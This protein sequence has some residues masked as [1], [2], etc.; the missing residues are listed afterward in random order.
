MGI[1]RWI[2]SVGFPHRI[3]TPLERKLLDELQALL[4]G[5]GGA[6]FAKQLDA[7]NLVQRHAHGQEVC[8]YVMRQGK[9]FEDPALQFPCRDSEAV[10]AVIDFS[11]A[12][13][14]RSWVA[15]FYLVNG[16]FVSIYFDP[17]PSAIRRAE[18]VHIENAR[19]VQDPMTA[20]VPPVLSSARPE[21]VQFPEWL[22]EVGSRTAIQG[23]SRP[24][25]SQER[26]LLRSRINA[27]LPLDYLELMELC[28]GFVIGDWSV[29]GLSETWEIR[30]PSGRYIALAERHGLGLLAVRARS[31][32]RMIYYL[33]YDGADPTAV[34]D[35]LRAALVRE[36]QER[37]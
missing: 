22:D 6:R 20:R 31:S 28:E 11:N 7:I 10:F 12:D 8:C 35:S 17:S 1:R 2:Q 27:W 24:I 5:E 15:E 4:T 33:G 37:K 23:V 21:D 18:D 25:E 34:G 19:I 13:R 3:F 36:G 30:T 26:R 32:E 14:S 16:Y 29:L 9:P